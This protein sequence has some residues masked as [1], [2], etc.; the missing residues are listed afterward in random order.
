[1]TKQKEFN[2]L[3]FLLQIT[4]GGLMIMSLVIDNVPTAIVGGVLYYQSIK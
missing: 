1:M 2:K 3:G 4:A